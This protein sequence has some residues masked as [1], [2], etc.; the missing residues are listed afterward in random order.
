MKMNRLAKMVA[1]GLLLAGG[2]MAAT[3]SAGTAHAGSWRCCP[4]QPPPSY[5]N[6]H[7]NP[8]WDPTVCHDYTFLA[9]NHVVEGIPCNT[10]ACPPGTVRENETPATPNIGE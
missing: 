10:F 8:A 3:F 1:A 4:G 2:A 5:G 9:P 7:T 6:I